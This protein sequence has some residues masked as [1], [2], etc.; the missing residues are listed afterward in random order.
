[1]EQKDDGDQT[2]KTFETRSQVSSFK[3][4]GKSNK[5]S[6]RSSA[7]AAAIKARAKAE[8]ACVQVSYAEKEADMMRQK[9]E[10]E[11][12]LYVLQKRRSA[13][14][15]SAEAAVYEA[16]AE[17]EEEPLED[18]AQ[19]TSENRVQRTSKYVE[20]HSWLPHTQQHA[21]VSQLQP[22]TFTHAESL[23]RNAVHGSTPG[24]VV[25]FLSNMSIKDEKID[26]M[27]R[28]DY[29][30]C[31]PPPMSHASSHRDYAW[32]PPQMTGLAKYLVRREMVS[33]GLLKFD[34]HPEN[35]WALENV[36]PR[37][38][39]RVRLNSQGGA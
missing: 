20:T 11:A 1:M 23:Q 12:N 7:S 28:A 22:G 9:A 19:L 29:S 16:A 30:R 8:A 10:L 25:N 26:D 3:S 36:F 32:E 18:L 35:Y 24:K 13:T 34:D 33:S 21:S 39:K 4:S 38:Y 31:P 14:A 37:C 27:G 2:Q 17:L 6:V 5:S 15:A